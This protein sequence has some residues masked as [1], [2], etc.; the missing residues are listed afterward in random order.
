MN[1]TSSI[2]GHMMITEK[3]QETMCYMWKQR[4]DSEDVLLCGNNGVLLELTE[5]QWKCLHSTGKQPD[6]YLWRDHLTCDLEYSR[7]KQDEI[8][9]L[10][11]ISMTLQLHEIRGDMRYTMRY[12]DIR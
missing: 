11:N 7:D 4:P 8:R 3:W 10:R 5:R 2:S 12:N 1:E 9:R 6:F